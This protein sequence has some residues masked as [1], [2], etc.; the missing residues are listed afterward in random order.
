MLGDGVICGGNE[1]EGQQIDRDR[2]SF[3]TSIYNN[4]LHREERS[5]NPTKPA[6][7]DHHLL[8]PYAT[9]TKE[10]H[11]AFAFVS[12]SHLGFVSS[13]GFGWGCVV[14]FNF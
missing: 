10:R 3:Y 7:N 6:T 4:N 1:E 9:P 11:L 12:R 14:P 5:T 2:I 8:L 13:G